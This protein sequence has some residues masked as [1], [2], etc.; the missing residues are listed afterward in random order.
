MSDTNSAAQAPWY[1]EF[2]FWFVFGPLIFIIIMCGFTV[3]IA[4]SGADD[5]IIDNYYKE[6]RMINQT[7]DQDKRAKALGLSAQAHFDAV[8]GEVLLTIDKLP[9]D[10]T[11]L[12]SELL[13]FMGHPVKAAKDQQLLLRAIGPG[14]YTGELKEPARYS[15]YLTL[16]PVSDLAMRNEADWT[17]SGEINFSLQ[18]TLQLNPRVK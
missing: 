12:P 16:Y 15:W 14:R 18:D 5:V 17:L 4:L 9:A 3:S 13:L 7:L 8:T 6:G 2:W 1:R 10:L 11:A